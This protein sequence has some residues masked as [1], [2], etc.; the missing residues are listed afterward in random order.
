[1][2]SGF[3]LGQGEGYYLCCGSQKFG[4]LKERASTQAKEMINLEESL[5]GNKTPEQRHLYSRMVE[6][7]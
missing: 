4:F 3:K 6:Y 1:M 7:L 5:K 2:Y